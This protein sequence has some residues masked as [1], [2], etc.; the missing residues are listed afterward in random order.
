VQARLLSGD[1]LSHGQERHRSSATFYALSLACTGC[2]T[3]CWYD[4]C[5]GKGRAPAPTA[6]VVG[7]GAQCPVLCW[8][9]RAPPAPRLP[10][11]SQTER[12]QYCSS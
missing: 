5:S 12:E 1:C 2:P 3:P 9:S 11:A 6:T 7:C 8:T 4:L 10:P